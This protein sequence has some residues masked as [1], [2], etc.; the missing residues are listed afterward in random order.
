[1]MSTAIQQSSCCFFLKKNV[2]FQRGQCL[3][4]LFSSNLV[5]FFFSRLRT[6]I[7]TDRPDNKRVPPVATPEAMAL[8]GDAAVE[9]LSKVNYLYF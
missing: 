3:S 2:E 9:T 8:I 5:A 4:N 7:A 1:M 6:H